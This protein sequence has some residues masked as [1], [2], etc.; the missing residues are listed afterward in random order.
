MLVVGEPDD[1]RRA[2]THISKEVEKAL[3]PKQSAEELIAAEA[4]AAVATG[5]GGGGT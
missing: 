2:V 4:T 5:S 3:E 1:V